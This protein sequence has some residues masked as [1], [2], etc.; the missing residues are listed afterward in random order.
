MRENKMILEIVQM[1]EPTQ[2][3]IPIK[4]NIIKDNNYPI[5]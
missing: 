1:T 5:H 2:L 4:M 3:M